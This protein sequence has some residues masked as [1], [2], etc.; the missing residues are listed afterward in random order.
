MAGKV[1][2]GDYEGKDISSFN[3]IVLINTS[4]FGSVEINKNTIATY[5]V[6]DQTSKKKVTSAVGRALVGSFLIG[7]AGIAA[8]VTAKKKG[9][10]IMALEFKDGKRSLIEIDDKTYKSIMKVLF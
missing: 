10:Y 4:W 2:A 7:P 3:T 1:I 8:G 5:E 9:K 6:I